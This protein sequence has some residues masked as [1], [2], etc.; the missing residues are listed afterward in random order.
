M[1]NIIPKTL[2]HYSCQV[3]AQHRDRPKFKA[4]YSSLVDRVV[5]LQNLSQQVCDG[6]DINTAVGVQ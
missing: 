6:Y 3:A 1:T 4:W 5:D 2:D